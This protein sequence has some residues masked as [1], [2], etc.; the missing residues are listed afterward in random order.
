MGLSGVRYAFHE[1][2]LEPAVP[3]KS[4]ISLS[5]AT[6]PPVFIQPPIKPSAITANLTDFSG[7][8]DACGGHRNHRRGCP[9]NSPLRNRG[10]V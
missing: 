5:W 7:F 4:F 10:P 2:W 3:A 8:C 6:V 9:P 1:D